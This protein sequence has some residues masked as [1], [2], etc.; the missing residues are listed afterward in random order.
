CYSCG[1]LSGPHSC[2][3]R[4]S[5][6]LKP[7]K[8]ESLAGKRV[9]VSGSGNVAIYANEKVTQLGGKVVAMCDSTG[10]IYDEDGVDLTT[11]KRIKEVDRKS[12]RL[13]SSHD[14][15]SYCVFL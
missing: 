11:I 3:T 6:D 5:S 7:V 9:V 14:S 1:D 13:N 12:T 4:R 8:G 15:T 10:W 2:P